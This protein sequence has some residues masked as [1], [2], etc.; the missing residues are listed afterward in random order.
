LPS[1]ADLRPRLISMSRDPFRVAMLVLIVVNL[2]RIHQS[3]PQLAPYRPGVL[4]TGIVAAIAFLKPG[5][6]AKG[7]LFRSWPMKLMAAFLVAACLSVPFG[8][9]PGSSGKAML[10]SYFKTIVFASLVVVSVRNVRDFYTV[11]WAMV[12]TNGI[13]SY[14]ALFVFQMADYGDLARLD[15]HGYTYDANDVGCVLVTGIGV[16]LVHMR[17]SQRVGRW[18]SFAILILMCASIAK[19][20]SR[21][22]MVGLVGAG[23]ALLTLGHG[24]S[25]GGRLLAVAGAVVGLTIWAPKGYW[26]QMQ[27]IL[28]PQEDYNYS[29]WDGRRHVALRGVGYMLQYPV[30]GIGIDN[31]SKA[32]CTISDR[33]RNLLPGMPIRCTPPHNSYV[34]AGA[35]LGVPGLIMWLVFIGGGTVA[36][37]LLRR[38]MPRRWK[39]GDAEE[40]HLYAAAALLPVTFV[41]Y[42]LTSL[43]LTFAWMEYSYMLMAVLAGLYSATRYKLLQNA[44]NPTPSLPH[45]TSNEWRSR[46]HLVAQVDVAT[47]P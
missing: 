13:L 46:N 30:F 15:Q 7:S 19:T 10:D 39:T 5:Y 21:G 14:M 36:P 18:I 16:T 17:S 40:R 26:K 22:A 12:I 42:G 11:T 41:G 37:V 32:E 25:L 29:A 9:S 6:L 20:G 47:A 4:L 31:F 28:D 3:L 44:S 24:V 1:K 43:F 2:S 38:K 23:V 27:T 34:Q 8:I 33:A 35:E 45:R